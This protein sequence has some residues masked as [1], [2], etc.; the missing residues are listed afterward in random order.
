MDTT[1]RVWLDVPHS[2][3]DEAKALGARWDAGA[4]RWY[5]SRAGADRVKRWEALPDVPDLLPGEDR[6]FGSG[7]FVDLVPDSCWF[8][9]VRSCVDQRDWE[10][11]RR[12]VTR[13]AGNVCEVCARPEDREAARWLEVH[14]RWTYDEARRIQSLRRLICLCTDCHRTTHFGLAQV[15]GWADEAFAH[16]VEVTGWSPHQADQHVSEAFDLW[17]RR[18]RVT[19][20]LDLGV[21]TGA[22]V[23]V[24][25]PPAASDRA[26]VAAEGLHAER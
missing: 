8:T 18:S 6:T 5:A 20:A 19:W 23:T 26:R 10:R 17:A 3:K 1:D 13:R 2:D 12:M 14:E 16:L 21:L 7:L 9:N 4:K 11:L 25:P 22:G 15:R 24:T